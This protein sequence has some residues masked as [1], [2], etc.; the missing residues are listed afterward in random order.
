VLVDVTADEITE[1]HAQISADGVDAERARAFVLAEEIGND[2]LRGRRAAGFADAD[3]DAR[4]RQRGHALGHAA[5][6]RHRAPERQRDRYNVAPVEA[7]RDARDRDAEQR[8]EQ[9]EAEACQETHR[10]VAER[11]LLFDRLDQDVEDGAVEKVQR[12]D[13]GEQGKHVI[14][15]DRQPWGGFRLQGRLRCEIDHGFPL[16]IAL[17]EPVGSRLANEIAR[18]EFH[19]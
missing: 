12:I 6:H 18:F 10:G 8:I 11:E 13:D 14:S 16:G 3:A 1:E 7:V 5:E 19:R 9:Y 2:R 4:Q 15:P 17:V